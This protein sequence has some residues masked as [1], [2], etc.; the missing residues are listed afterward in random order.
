M[1][2]K[3]EYIQTISALMKILKPNLSFTIF[4]TLSL[5]GP[6]L[7]FFLML[8]GKKTQHPFLLMLLSVV[9]VFIITWIWIDY[10]KGVAQFRKKI[11]TLWEE[12]SVLKKQAKELKLEEIEKRLNAIL[13]KFED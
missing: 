9:F 6:P 5:L 7:N 12:L 8:F 1:S 11:Y 13:E 4:I 3:K 2:T 10:A